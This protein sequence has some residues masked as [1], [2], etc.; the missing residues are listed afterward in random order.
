MSYQTLGADWSKVSTTL[1]AATKV[2]QDPHLSQLTCEVLR[3]SKAQKGEDPGPPCAPTVAT[4][5][6]GVG[7]SLAILPVKALTY[8]KRHPWFLPVVGVGIVGFV[9]LIGYAIGRSRT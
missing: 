5:Q 6:A 7:L 2:L 8:Q 3:L 4:K 1:E 9:M